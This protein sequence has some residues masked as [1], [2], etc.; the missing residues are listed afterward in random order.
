MEKNIWNL[1]EEQFKILQNCAKINSILYFNGNNES[2]ISSNALDESFT[3]FYVNKEFKFNI[4][5]EF[6]V[7]NINEILKTL[8]MIEKGKVYIND[9][10]IT[11][12][13]SNENIKCR[14]LYA[15]T[16]LINN[17]KPL[18]ENYDDIITSIKESDGCIKINFKKEYFENIKKFLTPNFNTISIKDNKIVL[19][20]NT[21]SNN[22]EIK[23]TIELSLSDDINIENRF[24][25]DIALLKIID[26]NDYTCYLSPDG[27]IL[28][29]NE[30]NGNIYGVATN[31]IN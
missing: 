17:I 30:K 10:Q 26:E 11:I 16:D 28:F 24:D 12:T 31:I 19:F 1:T 4:K 25:I 7:H 29:E 14:Y 21:G 5:K 6:V 2:I 13:D 8:K 3:I 27:Y 22:T 18:Y 9:T 20:D 15:D 23:D